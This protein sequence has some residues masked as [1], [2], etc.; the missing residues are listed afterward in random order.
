MIDDART[1]IWN[2]TNPGVISHNQ[3]LELYQKYIDPSFTWVNFSLEEQASVIKA[4]RSNNCLDSSKLVSCYPQISPIEIAIVQLFE[5][6]KI[7][8]K[9]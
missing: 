7:H 9:K 8:L 2:F 3:I 4:G 6:M 1:G 5:Q